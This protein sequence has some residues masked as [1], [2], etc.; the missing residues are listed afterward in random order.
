[1][2]RSLGMVVKSTLQP[3]FFFSFQYAGVFQSC[4][5]VDEKKGEKLIGFLNGF[6][7]FSLL[8]YCAG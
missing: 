8:C 5:K 6:W 1:M 4:H 7:V 2:V 3:E